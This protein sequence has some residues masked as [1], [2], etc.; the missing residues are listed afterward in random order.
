[1]RDKRRSVVFLL[2][3]VGLLGSLLLSCTQSVENNPVFRKKIAEMTTLQEDV[4]SLKDQLRQVNSDLTALR[5]DLIALKQT[6]GGLAALDAKEIESLRKR[7]AALEKEVG[8]RQLAEKTA[9]DT[10]SPKGETAT[11]TTAPVEKKSAPKATTPKPKTEAT[12]IAKPVE[13]FE[14]PKGHWYTIKSG[15]TLE[16]IARNQGVTVSSLISAN[17]GLSSSKPLIA[18]QKIWIPKAK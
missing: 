13:K 9:S 2:L 7:V 4:S 5:E 18:G 6:P 12:K 11:I 16:S 17:R 14:A 8:V 15:D 10:E 1:M 3:T